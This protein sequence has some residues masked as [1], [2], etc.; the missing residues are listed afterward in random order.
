MRHY[1]I[2]GNYNVY[3][4]IAAVGDMSTKPK[5]VAGGAKGKKGK[6][7][8][9]GEKGE[10]DLEERYKKTLHEITSLRVE[11]GEHTLVIQPGAVLHRVLAAG[12][13]VLYMVQHR[14]Q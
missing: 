2:S 11:L 5:K 12:V 9:K 6:K 8:K 4:R 13:G 1:S 14:L 10:K 7:V 3:N